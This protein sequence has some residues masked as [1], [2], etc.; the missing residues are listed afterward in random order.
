MS[1]GAIFT[2]ILLGTIKFLFAPLS[3]A[4]MGLS[5]FEAMISSLIGAWLSA[6]IFY[7]LSDHFLNK[8]REKRLVQFKL[9]GEIPSL[10]KKKRL[11]NRFILKIKK[12]VGQV[13]ICFLA[14][15][16]LSVPLG[17]II[18]AKFYFKKKYT[19]ILILCGLL[20]NSFLLSVISFYLWP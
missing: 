10:S 7:H 4:G 16:F 6:S 20:I 1:W 14:P 18:C 17:T 5:F 19:F 9:T 11:V 13:G 15:L 3:G 12:S 8:A 2:T